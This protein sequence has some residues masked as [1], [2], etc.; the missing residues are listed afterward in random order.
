[1]KMRNGVKLLIV[2]MAFVSQSVLADRLETFLTEARKANSCKEY[3]KG[4]ILYR[5]YLTVYPNHPAARKELSALLLRAHVEDPHSIELFEF[6]KLSSYHPDVPG[7]P[8]E[9]PLSYLENGL[10]DFNHGASDFETLLILTQIFHHDTNQALKNASHLIT[11]F[12]HDPVLHNLLGLSF[13]QKKYFN[14]ARLHFQKALS[15][16]PDFYKSG[17]NLAACELECGHY[18]QA[19]DSL[20]FI[21]KQDPR[22]REANLLMAEVARLQGDVE[23]EKQIL[24]NIL[25]DL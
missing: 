21:L 16:K 7:L 14:E 9:F 6:K 18:K 23:G 25:Q 1:M 2:L 15:L 4:I 11:R 22:H 19:K 20:E 5:K 3:D 13:Y 8:E 12:P 17:I 24:Q 10:L